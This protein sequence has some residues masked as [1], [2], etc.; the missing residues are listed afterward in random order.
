MSI[1]DQVWKQQVNPDNVEE[2]IQKAFYQI[3]HKNIDTIHE[4]E[5]EHQWLSSSFKKDSQVNINDKDKRLT[6]SFQIDSEIEN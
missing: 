2:T 6:R 1:I 4:V 5:E 3:H